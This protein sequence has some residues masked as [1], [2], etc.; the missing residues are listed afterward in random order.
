MNSAEIVEREPKRQGR[1]QVRPFFREGVRQASQAAKVH[2]HGQI[3]A[4]NM[5]RA[6]S[7]NVWKPQNW[8]GFGTAYFG[9][10]IPLLAFPRSP[11]N[12]YDLPVINPATHKMFV[13]RRDMGREAVRGKLVGSLRC[14]PEDFGRL[15][16]R[17]ES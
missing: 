1:F 2:S 16:V 13:N 5:R 14:G 10:R 17:G 8:V 3:A 15:G 9:G 7:S 11:M 4:F 12:F 6:N